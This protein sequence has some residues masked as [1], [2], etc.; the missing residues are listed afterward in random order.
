MS[1]NINKV[2]GLGAAVLTLTVSSAFAASVSTSG[3]LQVMSGPGDTY[4]VVG[5]ITGEQTVSLASTQ[6]DWCQI[7]SP[8]AGWVPC[9]QLSGLNRTNLGT[10]LAPA[11]APKAT[12][13]APIYD[14][15]SDPVIGNRENP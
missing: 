15:K 1:I 3:N 5:E 13:T 11:P 12:I 10:S 9:A 8:K 6:G 4:P 7:T 2:I 14:P